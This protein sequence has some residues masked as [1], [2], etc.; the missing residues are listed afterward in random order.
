MFEGASGFRQRR[1]KVVDLTED[2]PVLFEGYLCKRS[3]GKLPARWQK[4]YFK[5]DRLLLQ[6]FASYEDGR[7][8][9]RAGNWKMLGAFDLAQVR[10]TEREIGGGRRTRGGGGHRG[11]VKARDWTMG[12]AVAGGAYVR[13]CACVGVWVHAHVL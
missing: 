1:P 7:N 3:S 12:R 10:R 6:Y 9:C 2:G 13:V 11:V 4:R 8:G 5:L